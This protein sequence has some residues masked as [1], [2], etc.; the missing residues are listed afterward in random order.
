MKEFI[1]E[2]R[3]AVATVLI[4]GATLGGFSLL[5]E[6]TGTSSESFYSK[7]ASSQTAALKSAPTASVAPPAPN[8]GMSV[9]DHPTLCSSGSG[10]SS[11]AASS[12]SSSA[13]SAGASSSPMGSFSAPQM[14][15]AKNRNGTNSYSSGLGTGGNIAMAGGGTIFRSDPVNVSSGASASMAPTRIRR[16]APGGSD[17]IFSELEIYKGDL[18]GIITGDENSV[19]DNP[20]ITSYGQPIGDALLPL[21]LLI[22]IYTLYK[23]KKMK[24]K[25]ATHVILLLTILMMGVLPAQAQTYHTEQYDFDGDGILETYNVVYIDYKSGSDT[26]NGE[27]ASK[28]VKSWNIAYSKLPPYT[29][30]TVAERDDAWNQNIIVVKTNT[31]TSIATILDNHTGNRPATLTGEWP[32]VGAKTVTGGR[33]GVNSTVATTGNGGPRIGADTR[34]KNITIYSVSGSTGRMSL[35]LHDALFDEGV[36]MQNFSDLANNMGAMDGRKAPDFHLLLYGDQLDK[37]TFEQNKPMTL[38]IKSGRYGRI[39]ASRIAGTK[40]INTYVI[41]RH[42]NPLKAIIN[43]DI[44][45]GNP[46]GLSS[47]GA[48]KNYKDDIAYLCAGLTQGMVYADEVFNITRGSIAYVVAGSQG[49]ALDMGTL[50]VPVSTFAGRVTVNVNAANNSDV[51]IQEYYG[52]CQGRVSDGSRKCNAYFYGESTLNLSGG[53]IEASVYA[54]AGGISGLKNEDG[55]VYTSDVTIPYPGSYAHGV[56]YLPY[57]PQKTIVSITSTFNGNIDLSS[58]MMNINISGGVVKNNVYGGSMGYSASLPVANAPYHAGRF[59]GNTSISISGGTIEGN[60]YGGGAGDV[61]YY[62]NAPSQKKSFEDVAEVYGDTYITIT[63]NPTIVGN[64][65]GG[66]AGVPYQSAEGGKTANEFLD[67]AK[68]HGDTHVTINPTDPNWTFTG[69]IYGGGA[70]GAVVGNTNVA[71]RGGIILGNVFAAGQGEEGHPNKAKV[72]GTTN[73]SVGKEATK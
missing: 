15:S 69:N 5:S 27:S 9:V 36:V 8:T 42:T 26:Y 14:N 25:Q 33:F 58:T 54:S 23:Y 6:D 43:I 19:M 2:I 68:V 13:S 47:A 73:V 71:I 62:N 18:P 39:M 37:A 38:T 35:Y 24:Y 72:T 56:D 45:P 53:T 12:A 10:A 11:A 20:I 1:M 44:Q 63:G 28:P 30:T 60:V 46:D 29:G 67:I 49:N 4:S 32:W 7:P 65:Y 17:D 3:L 48:N 40:N 50:I 16:S 55:S 70:K 21:L 51:T 41:G 66:G 57:D 52:A 64:I 31:G 61:T 59:F 34:F 22:M